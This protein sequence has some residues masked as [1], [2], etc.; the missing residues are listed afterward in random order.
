M[1]ASDL[2]I[3][4]ARAI[5]ADRERTIRQRGHAPG[6]PRRGTDARL[7]SARARIRA[8]RW[9]IQ[10]G[11]AGATVPV[12]RPMPDLRRQGLTLSAAEG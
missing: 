1:Y 5:Q 3:I 6:R 12:Q 7:R 2:T 10:P 9:W 8:S 4:L 11:T